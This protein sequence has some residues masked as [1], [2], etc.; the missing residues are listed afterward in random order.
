M[1]NLF[2]FALGSALAAALVAQ[3][4]FAQTARKPA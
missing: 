2:K 4:G 1:T 3:P